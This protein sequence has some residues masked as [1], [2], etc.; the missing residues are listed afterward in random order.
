MVT[1]RSFAPGSRRCMLR[2]ETERG[3]DAEGAD[4]FW[5]RLSEPIHECTPEKHNIRKQL[6]NHLQAGHL[7]L[8]FTKAQWLQQGAAIQD[9]PYTASRC[10]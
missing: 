8:C 9:G 2:G 4:V 5:L 6:Y 10:Q 3:V 7:V 1:R